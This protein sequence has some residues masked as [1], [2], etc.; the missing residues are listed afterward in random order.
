MENSKSNGRKKIAMFSAHSD[1]LAHLGSQECGGQNIYERYLMEELEKFGWD[2]DFFTRWDSGY[3]KQIANITKHCRVIRLKAGPVSYV[4]RDELFTLF[5]ELFSGFLAFTNFEN[6]YEIFHGHYWDGGWMA[7]EA[8]RKFKKP[9]IQN[10]HSLGKIRM[11]TKKKY[12]KN[13]IDDDYFTK[14][15][16]LESDIIKEASMI[17]SLSET[18]KQNLEQLYRCPPEKNIVI[19]GGINLKHWPLMEKEKARQ[20]LCLSGKEFVVLFIGRLEWRKGIGTLISACGMLKKE[21]PNLKII[22]VGGKIFG[23]IT[24]SADVKEYKR[25]IEKAKEDKVEDITTFSGNIDHGQLPVFYRA[26]DVFVVPSYYEPFGLVA[27]ESMASKIPVIASRVGGLMTI[28]KNNENGL[29]FEPRNALD[30]KEK[31]LLIYKSKESAQKLAENAYKDIRENYS[32]HQIV[33]KINEIYNNLINK[34]I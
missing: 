15:F 6:P 12:K 24:N 20:K 23:K 10:F 5:P 31:I 11:E 30:L 27:L 17:I 14:R 26:S 34:N 13:S 21:I 22:I 28:I 2:V 29:L 3:K 7:L 32:W 1:P 33:K 18:E 16:N 8:H 19:P 4:P 25:L 9:F